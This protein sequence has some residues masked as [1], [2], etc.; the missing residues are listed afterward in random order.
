MSEKVQACVEVVEE[1]SDVTQFIFQLQASIMKGIVEQ[2]V[3]VQNSHII[4]K[5]TSR[6]CVW[7]HGIDSLSDF[8]GDR[9]DGEVGSARAKF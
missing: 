2:N 3:D 8:G 9:S 4:F 5:R 1:F 7:S 6:W